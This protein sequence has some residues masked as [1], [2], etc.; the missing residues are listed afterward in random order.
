[1]ADTV[2]KVSYGYVTVGNR[3][4]QGEKILAAIKKAGINLLAFSAFPAKAGQSQLDLVAENMSGIRRLARTQGW[5]LSRPKRG[6]LIQG[7]DQVGAVHRHVR[8]LAQR[9]INVTAGQALVAGRGRWGMILWVRPKDYG[10][11]ARALGAR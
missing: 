6:F 9:N 5:R 4:G 8:K 11:A 10:R 1:M 3:P 7:T 2:R